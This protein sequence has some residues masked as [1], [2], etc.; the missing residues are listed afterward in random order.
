MC[1]IHSLRLKY[2]LRGGSWASADFENRI[3][4]QITNQAI[5]VVVN[6]NITSIS[7]YRKSFVP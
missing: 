6:L 1:Q 7:G 4:G 5:D 2:S 3:K